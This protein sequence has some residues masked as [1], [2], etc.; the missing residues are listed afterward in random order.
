MLIPPVID[1]DFLPEPVRQYIRFLETT[2]QQLQ[3]QVRDLEARLNKNSSNSSKDLLNNKLN[4]YAAP[5]RQKSTI[6]KWVVS[7]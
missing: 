6:I 2:V 4:H 3:T 1:F 5:K 7:L